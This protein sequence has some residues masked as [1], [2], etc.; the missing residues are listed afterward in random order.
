MHLYLT[1]LSTEFSFFCLLYGSSFHS[2]N[3]LLNLALVESFV[4]T[5]EGLK[6]LTITLNFTFF[7]METS[8]WLILLRPCIFLLLVMSGTDALSQNTIPHEIN[9]LEKV[10]WIKFDPQRDNPSFKICDEYNIQEYYQVNPRYGEGAKSI[11]EYFE[12]IDSELG[13]SKSFSG[14]ITVRFLINCQGEVDRVRVAAVNSNFISESIHQEDSV[15]LVNAVKN[16]GLWTP[17]VEGGIK[18]DCYKH[19]IFKLE[20]GILKDILA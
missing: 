3:K 13:L 17:G 8:R 7:L 10:G 20:N 2:S 12:G 16:M 19:I 14:Y 6:S 18:Y 11:R 4:Q 9:S 15:L 1:C 5:F